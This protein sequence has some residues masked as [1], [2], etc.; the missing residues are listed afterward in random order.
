MPFQ[1]QW[2]P[3]L[4]RLLPGRGPPDGGSQLRVLGHDFSARSAAFGLLQCRFNLTAVA[5]TFVDGSEVRCGA[6]SHAEGAVEVE[7]T[8]NGLDWTRDGVVFEYVQLGLIS[9]WPQSGPIHGRAARGR[10][11]LAA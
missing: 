10:T 7:L 6:P 3:R 1:Y 11:G 4:E 8:D 9:L 5:A 2:Q